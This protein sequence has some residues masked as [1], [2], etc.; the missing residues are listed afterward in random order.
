LVDKIRDLGGNV[1]LFSSGHVTGEKL[2]DL[3]GV[4]AILRFP[5]N[6]DYLD[7]KEDVAVEESKQDDD[8]NDDQNVK[9]AE[10]SEFVNN[11]EMDKEFFESLAAQKEKQGQGQ[12]QGYNA[13]SQEKSNEK[14]K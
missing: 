2:N 8:E 3:S 11:D 10:V 1:Y 6:M 12:G 14:D 4:A 7:E 9:M 5:C 13:K